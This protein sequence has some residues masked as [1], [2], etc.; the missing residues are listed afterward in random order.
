MQQTITL[1][2]ALSPRY[3]VVWL[4]IG[5]ARA[6]TYLPLRLQIWLGKIIGRLFYYIAHSRRRVGRINLKLCFPEVDE[7]IRADWLYRC[8][9]N[10]GIALMETSLA[11]WGNEQ[12]FQSLGHI[13]GLEHIEAAKKS[14]RPIMFLSCHMTCT[15]IS[16][17]FLRPHANIQVMYKKS[18]NALFERIMLKARSDL[19]KDVIN[20]KN[21][22]GLIKGL[23]NGLISWYA[24]DQNF[25]HHDTVFAP[26]FGVQA[27]TL[28]ATARMAQLTNAIILPFFPY[29]TS[30]APYYKVVVHPPVE[31]FPTGDDVIDAATTNLIM[32]RAIRLAPEQY[33]WTHKRFKTRPAG[34]PNIY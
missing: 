10:I 4:W 18:K 22:R 31:N 13:E 23:R 6:I 2:Q 25:G 30:D 24:P 15:E 16:G 29:R 26:F 12:R 32:E 34:E 5:I 7:K 28:T 20:S 8:F 17:R 19:Y 21:T 33:L 1:R 3:I 27:T 11:W 9:E 14:G